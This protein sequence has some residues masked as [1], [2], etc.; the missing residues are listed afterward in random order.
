MRCARVAVLLAVLMVTWSLPF[1]A[2]AQLGLPLPNPGSLL[3]SITSPNPGSTVTQTVIVKASVTIIGSLTVAGVQFKLDGL[4]LGAEDTTNEYSVSWDTA[5]T[6]NGWHNLTAVARDILGVQWSSDQVQVQVFND[7]TPPTVAITSPTAGAIVAGT[8]TVSADASD[9]VGVV[10]VQFKLDGNDLGMEDTTNWFSVSWDTTKTTDGQHTLTAV[11][12]D[13]AG[14]KG[15]SAPV[16]V[17]VD[18]TPA[19]VSIG[20]PGNGQTVSGVVTVKAAASDASGVAVVQFLRDGVELARDTTAPYEA[21]WDTQ[22]VGNGPHTLQARAQDNAGNIGESAIVL[23]TVSNGPPP[24]SDTTPPTVAITSPD[25]SAPVS[26][27]I[28]VTA[29]ASDNVAVAGVQFF[30]DGALLDQD[31]TAPYAVSWDTMRVANGSYTL[32]ARA[33]DTSGNPATSPPVAVTVLNTTTTRF[34]ETAAFLTPAGEWRVLSPADLSVPL[35]GDRAVATNTAGATATFTFTGIGVAWRGVR[36]EVCGKARVWLDGVVVS[37]V[38]TFAATRSAA[39]LYAATALGAATHT[40]IIEVTGTKG[41]ASGGAFV[42]V[43][44]FDVTSDGTTPSRFEETAATLA[45][46]GAWISESSTE[47]GI[48][49]TAGHVVFT[50]V[51]GATAT[52]TFTGTGVSW[53]SA[54]CELCGIARVWLDG[55]VVREAV[56]TYVLYR[57]PSVLFS[58]T[59]LRAATHTIMIEV[60]GTRNASSSSTAVAVDAFDVTP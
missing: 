43:D 44:A 9:N 33:Q 25:G 41:D 26:G 8:I 12:R 40:L 24:T 27:T 59:G 56:D 2:Y 10:G 47:A 58:V 29:N 32:T 16:T 4:N 38:D 52:F 50:D 53:L 3:V 7:K 57:S 54:R 18:N 45:P 48:P 46:A 39:V 36:C 49:L 5:A 55:V 21:L 42:I 34:E 51:A 13:A 23:V 60:T 11:A 15:V 20:E 30:V 14:N 31:T 37:E 1:E 28:T 19:T 22:T 35:S 6:N 17:R